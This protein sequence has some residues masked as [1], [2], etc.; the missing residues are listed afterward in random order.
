MSAVEHEHEPEPGHMAPQHG[1]AGPSSSYS[2][3][4]LTLT[5]DIAKQPGKGLGVS[6]KCSVEGYDG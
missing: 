2:E 1:P 4:S 3:G 6:I 5:H